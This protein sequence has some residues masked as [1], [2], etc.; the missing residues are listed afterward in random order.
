MI[1]EGGSFGI[2]RNKLDNVNRQTYN[3]TVE[4]GEHHD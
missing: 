1:L 2:L 3:E 4:S